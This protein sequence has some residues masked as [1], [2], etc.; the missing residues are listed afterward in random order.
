[1][2]KTFNN[3]YKF[4]GLTQLTDIEGI[5]ED[6]DESSAYPV[7]MREVIFPRTECLNYRVDEWKV[8]GDIYE[9]VL[10]SM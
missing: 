6:K 7:K 8:K 4:S 5:I 3:F 2:S 10:Q 1:M 9:K